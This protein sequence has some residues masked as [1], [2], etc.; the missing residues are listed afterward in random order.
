MRRYGAGG[1]GN[2][3]EIRLSIF[4][5]RRGHT[6]DDGIHVGQAGKLCGR[7]E[8]LRARRLDL[9]RWNSTNVGSPRG[10]SCDLMLVDVKTRYA[11]LRFGVEQS[12]RQTHITQ[13]Y[14]DYPRLA[15]INSRFQL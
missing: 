12:K 2:E 9:C 6:D 13:A 8:T 7:T 3:T 1:I 5:Q 10:E 11:K 15:S 4:V 14:H